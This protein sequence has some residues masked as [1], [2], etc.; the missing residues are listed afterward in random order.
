MSETGGTTSSAAAPKG[1][2][3]SNPLCSGG[4]GLPAWCAGAGGLP[5][6]AG[7][8]GA[9]SPPCPAPVC[10]DS[11]SGHGVSCRFSPVSGCAPAVIGG[12]LRCWGHAWWGVSWPPAGAE[13]S[14]LRCHRCHRRAWCLPQRTHGAGR[15]LHS[16]ESSEA[17]VTCVE[18]GEGMV[19][20]QQ[21][22]RAATCLRV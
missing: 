1:S 21:P 6:A 13:A 20:K 7:W 22:P 10:A 18:A 2:S 17:V 15:A 12:K 4:G 9:C 11:W 8:A 16:S 19:G 14:H 5:A 3:N